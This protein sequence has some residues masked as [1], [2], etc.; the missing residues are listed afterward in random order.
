M[1]G[2]G[3]CYDNA[4]VE[5]FFKTI[6]IVRAAIKRLHAIPQ[7]VSCRQDKD[8]DGVAPGAQTG[9]QVHAVSVREASDSQ[10]KCNTGMLRS[11]DGQAL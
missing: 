1:S 2:K 9:E 11:C 4:V 8:R 5:T 6:V 3:N 10:A 7:P